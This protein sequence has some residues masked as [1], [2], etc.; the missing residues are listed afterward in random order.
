MSAAAVSVPPQSG[1]PT[2]VPP[3]RPLERSPAPAAAGGNYRQVLTGRQPAPAGPPVTPC[4]PGAVPVPQRSL[5]RSLQS[6]TTWLSWSWHKLLLGGIATMF[7][8]WLI[9][10]ETFVAL[11][12]GLLLITGIVAALIFIGTRKPAALAVGVITLT[13]R[14]TNLFDWTVNALWAWLIVAGLAAVIL[15][16]GTR[17]VA[18]NRVLPRAALVLL[19]VLA[20]LWTFIVLTGYELPA[21]VQALPTAEPVPMTAWP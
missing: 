16:G 1:A 19:L 12:N 14:F 10:T 18:E 21:N 20:V 5:Q 15:G 11:V 2:T 13:V 7:A 4:I 9:Q 6:L 8:G 3:A 17:I